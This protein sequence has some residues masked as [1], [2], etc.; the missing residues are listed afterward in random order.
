MTYYVLFFIDISSRAVHVA[1]RDDILNLFIVTNLPL[2][3]G[4][5]STVSNS[6]DFDGDIPF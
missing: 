4:A 1:G 6:D 2:P 3:K 5:L